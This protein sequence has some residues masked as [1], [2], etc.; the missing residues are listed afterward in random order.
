MQDLNYALRRLA[1][2]PG[3][4]LLTVLT[5]ALGIGA[6]TAI[7]SVVN[8]VL[9]RPVAVE[10]PERVMLIFSQKPEADRNMLSPVDFLAWKR[11]GRVFAAISP[12]GYW[13][14]N[15]TGLSAPLEVLGARVDGDYFKTM[16]MKPVV[17]RAL[18]P[19]DDE[20]G[21]EKVVVLRHSFWQK[22]VGG[23]PHVIGRHLKLSGD[24]YTV[25]GVMP[26]TYIYPAPAN[27]WLP[28]AF[29]P[30]ESA[31]SGRY[32]YAIGRLA[33]G[34]SVRRARAEMNVIAARLAEQI[35][36]DKGWGVN[37]LPLREAMTDKPRTSLLILLSAAGLVLL[38]A[39]ANVASLMLARSTSRSREIAVRSALG[40]GRRRVLRQLLTE[41]LLL[42][43]AGGTAGV[44]LALL[45]LKSLVLLLAST[46]PRQDEV[47]IDSRVLLVSLALSL[48][49]GLLFG[50]APILYALR[51]DMVGSLK[52]GKGRS[53]GGPHR[54]R[55]LKIFL[56]AEVTLAMMIL[57]GAGLLFRS[58][59]NL[60]AVDTGFATKN[61]L[62]APLAI[63]GGDPRYQESHSRLV[64]YQQVMERIAALPG[65]SHVGAIDQPP[66]KWPATVSSFGIVGRP[67]PP[68]GEEHQAN[69]RALQGNY[70]GAMEIPL[71]RGRIFTDNE[72]LQKAMI[73]VVNKELA[74][75]YW[76]GESP[77]GHQVT[78]EDQT[79]TIVG[80]VGNSKERSLTEPATPSIYY[81]ER[82]PTS[83]TLMIRTASNLTPLIAGVRQAVW[84]LD[85]ELP[86][87]DI[88]PW[89]EQLAEETAEPRAK[90]E[91]FGVFALL[92]LMLAAMGIYGITAYFVVQRTDEIGVRLALGARPADV[93]GMIVRQGLSLA[94]IGI[95]IGL[96]GAFAITRVL[97]SLLFGVTPHDPATFVA[98]TVFL[99]VVALFASFVPARRATRIEPVTALRFE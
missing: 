75:K 19:S 74:D 63:P 93:Q 55:P 68:A 34:V 91:L 56:V 47:A 49:T 69:V 4:S 26:P 94:L 27:L 39:C 23:D 86:L 53:G 84:S 59:A 71:L 42:A 15:V 82:N 41:S 61:V 6:N 66:L 90:A 58:L 80:V 73:A 43:L 46:I 83:M 98:V 22:Y 50:L 30:E 18:L 67:K 97:T 78:V 70:F 14:Y 88:K 17:G 32:L 51:L 21:A 16:S 38:I 96:A 87:E 76:P 44:L 60:Q 36:E 20:P 52:E 81:P 1:R 25:V 2:N 37:V 54:L 85:P 10:H 89:G 9:L 13:R 57:M 31:R 8:T 65:V 77:L 72:I 3:F 45:S 64:F 29:T 11:Q 62:R 33:P 92:A 28:A 12:I 35:P 79:M 48:L 95:V 99:L 40:A 7:F 5:L 24:S